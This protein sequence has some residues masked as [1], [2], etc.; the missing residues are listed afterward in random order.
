MTAARAM[1]T[2]RAAHRPTI[3]PGAV[4]DAAGAGLAPAR[5]GAGRR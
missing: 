2:P 4:P 5:R 3:V 1:I